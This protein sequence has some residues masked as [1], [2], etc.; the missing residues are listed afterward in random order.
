MSEK[1]IE[2]LILS[3]FQYQPDCFAMKYDVKGTWDP[4][5]KFFRKAGKGVALGGSDILLF[6]RNGC[7]FYEVKTPEKY[8]AFYKRPG[9]HELRQQGFME[10]VR[11][12]GHFAEVVCSLEQVMKHYESLKHVV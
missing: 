12:T 4:G 8:A 1:L 6:S 3:W 9:P 10:R 7:G 5:R 11:S 2:N